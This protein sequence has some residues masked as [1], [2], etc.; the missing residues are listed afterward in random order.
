[1]RAITLAALCLRTY[2]ALT[3]AGRPQG[4][5]QDADNEFRVDALARYA[6]PGAIF[7][8]NQ[9]NPVL[10]L[11]PVAVHVAVIFVLNQVIYRRVAAWLTAWENHAH[12]AEHRASLVA[13]RVLFEAF[14]CYVALFYLA[15]WQLDAL[16]VRRELQALFTA[17]CARRLATE[18]V[19]PWM[20]QSASAAARPVGTSTAPPRT[21]CWP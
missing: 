6:A 19:L 16:K 18:V 9:A 10:P 7:D 17:D 21:P 4:Y 1:M 13:K 12:E 11:V 8:P 20:M 3:Q 14:D 5:I 15:F 2:V